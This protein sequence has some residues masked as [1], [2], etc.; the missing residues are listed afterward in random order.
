M[1]VVFPG[2]ILVGKYGVK[3][4]KRILSKTKKAQDDKN[5]EEKPRRQQQCPTRN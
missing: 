5:T 4:A 1:V 2:L 3:E